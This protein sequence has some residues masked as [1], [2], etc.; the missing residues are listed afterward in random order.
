M[1]YSTKIQ[2][3]IRKSGVEQYYVNFPL[4]LVEAMGFEKGE[5]IEWIIKDDSTIV[6]RRP[7]VSASPDA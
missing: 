6:A 4:A 5:V 1:G 2:Q 3:I 7:K